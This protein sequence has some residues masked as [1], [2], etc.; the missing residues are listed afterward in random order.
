M[1]VFKKRKKLH[2]QSLIG[3]TDVETKILQALASGCRSGEEIMAYS[4]LPPEVY[5]ET[6]TLLEIKGRVHSL[7]ANNW[8][9]M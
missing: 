5:N 4:L 8:S 6:I 1:N 9:L 2:Q 3:D 7:G